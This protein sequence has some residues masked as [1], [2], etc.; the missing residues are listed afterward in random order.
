LCKSIH[1]K[2]HY[3]INY[4]K[5]YYICNLHKEF[6][7]NYCE[8]CKLNICSLC[9]NEHKGHKVIA[10]KDIIP[11]ISD[12]KNQ[13]NY[14]RSK[15]DE[16]NKIIKETINKLNKIIEN[17]EIYYNILKNMTE[18]YDDKNINYEI[19]QNIKEL[20]NSNYMDIIKEDDLLDIYYKLIKKKQIK[21]YEDGKYEGEF[22][23]K[24][25]DGKGIMYYNNGNKYEGEWKNDV[26]EGKG[27]MYYKSQGHYNK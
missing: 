25:R 16:A 2:Y 7:S 6:Y 13:L 8:E 26:K 19:L 9:T 14:I 20:K 17:N 3:I 11:N 15:I 27:I 1:D 10:Y 4:E 22:K 18:S 21:T 24:L 12:I 23:N 5:Q